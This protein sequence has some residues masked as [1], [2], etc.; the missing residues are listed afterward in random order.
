M[1]SSRSVASPRTSEEC[2][3]EITAMI[4][5]PSVNTAHF[6]YSRFRWFQRRFRMPSAAAYGSTDVCSIRRTQ[7]AYRSSASK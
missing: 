3:V 7:I 5:A 2:S 4:S 1:Y 6:S